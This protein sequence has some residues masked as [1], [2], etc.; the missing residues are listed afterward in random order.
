MAIVRSHTPVRQSWELANPSVD[1]ARE[2]LADKI[3]QARAEE[4]Q[5]VEAEL[6]AERAACQQQARD[7]E[8]A[9]EHKQADY[10]KRWGAALGVLEGLAA[11][12]GEIE[13]ATLKASEGEM[14]RLA[15]AVAGQVLRREVEA[16]ST[17]IDAI[18]K[19]LLKQVPDRRNLR[20]SL[21]PEE[22]ARVREQAA[23]I[24]VAASVPIEDDPALP[25]GACVIASGGSEIEGNVGDTWER[26]AAAMRAAAP[27][28]S[29]QGMSA[30]LD[31]TG[32]PAPSQADA[33]D[34]SDDAEPAS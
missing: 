8:K 12:L 16:D 21:R 4:R 17:W 6:A 34:P 33:E 11:R 29:S 32:S 5:A 14:V 15:L 26:V 23:E 1:R 31:T 25:L 24:G 27:I 18:L 13:Q 22:A 3:A 19:D 9:C 7:A 20:V 10:E 28:A 30:T 2:A